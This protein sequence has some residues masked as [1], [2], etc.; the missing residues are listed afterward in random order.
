MFFIFAFLRRSLCSD[1]FIL[2]SAAEGQV[3]SACLPSLNHSLSSISWRVSA[4]SDYLKQKS[5]GIRNRWLLV[6]YDRA[7]VHAIAKW[8]Q[9]CSDFCLVHGSLCF[10]HVSQS[11]ACHHRVALILPK[12]LL[13]ACKPPQKP[14]PVATNLCFPFCS[15]VTKQNATPA[16]HSSKPTGN[17]K[18]EEKHNIQRDL[19]KGQT[20]RWAKGLGKGKREPVKAVMRLAL[21]HTSTLA[22]GGPAPK[23]GGKLRVR[24][25]KSLPLFQGNTYIHVHPYSLFPSNSPI[26]S[27]VIK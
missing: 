7:H 3:H 25:T 23:N 19:A 5:S 21:T 9:G 17:H 11:L 22:G 27:S 4:H 16:S 24:A 1:C 26:A 8:E 15:E 10:Q 14:R 6:V 18:S 13:S 20:L 2:R 12:A